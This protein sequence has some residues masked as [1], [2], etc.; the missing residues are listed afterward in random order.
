MQKIPN[1]PFVISLSNST[2]LRSTSVVKNPCSFPSS[3]NYLANRAAVPYCV[4]KYIEI[5][6]NCSLP[7]ILFSGCVITS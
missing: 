3:D 5:G 6:I 2:S 4:P 1:F 7:F